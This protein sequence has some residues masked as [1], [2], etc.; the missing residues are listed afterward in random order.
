MPALYC[1]VPI[2]RDNTSIF[3]AKQGN[4]SI[5]KYQPIHWAVTGK[6]PRFD[7]GPARVHLVY[8]DMLFNPEPAVAEAKQGCDIVLLFNHEITPEHHL[9][10]DVR[11]IE[12]IAVAACSLNAAGI[13]ITPERHQRWDQVSA[14]HGE[15]CR[16]PLD[17]HRT[18]LKRFQDR[19]DFD[20][21]L[22]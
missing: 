2:T 3:S 9:L 6:S 15:V 13:W 8:P 10:A 18:R 5:G 1:A 12:N 14:E 16:Y 17:T 7:F 22:R 11:T 20:V 4:S 21:L 19:I